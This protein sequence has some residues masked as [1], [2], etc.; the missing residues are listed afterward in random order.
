MLILRSVVSRFLVGVMILGA[1][2]APG[3]N[4]PSKPIRIFT[5]PAG[6]GG[7]FVSRIVAEGIS[8]SLGQPIIVDN[9]SSNLIAGLTAAALPDGYTWL[10]G[11]GT[12][13]A[14]PLFTK[15]TYDAVKDFSPVSS[16]ITTASILV[17]HPSLPVKS[18]K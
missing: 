12:F 5:S 16:L 2:V 13:L 8:G 17:V 10:I 1:A 9:R 15:T 14:A 7:D 3:Q 11:G 18:V 6:G 4:Y